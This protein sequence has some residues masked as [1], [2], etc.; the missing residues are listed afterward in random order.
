VNVPKD[1]STIQ[2]AIDNA[3]SLASENTD[4]I[5]GASRTGDYPGGIVLKSGI[6]LQAGNRKDYHQRRRNWV[7]VTANSITGIV[8]F[9]NLRLQPLHRHSG[10]REFNTQNHE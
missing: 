6:S 5:F 4:H 1:F 8:T 7:A 3:A 10:Y 2:A 9:S